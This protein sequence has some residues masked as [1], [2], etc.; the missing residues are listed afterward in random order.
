MSGSWPKIIRDP[1]HDLIAFEDVP[2]DRLLLDLLNAREVQRL[3]R[4]KQLG[5]TELVFPAANH[6][7]FAHSLGVLHI[8]RRFLDRF[9]QLTGH[10]LDEERRTLVLAAAL[11]HDVGHGP[12]SHA[13]EKVTG[14]NHERYTL[15]I[16]LDEQTEVHQKLRA[17]S[18]TLPQQ[19]AQFF[20]EETPPSGGGHRVPPYL[21]QIISSQLDADRCDYLLRDSH[22]TGTNYGNYDLSWLLAQ[23]R[24]Q[25]DGARFYLSRKA[26]SVAEAYLFARAHMYRTVYFHKTTRAAE[27]MLRLL[28]QRFKEL[29]AEA[30][31]SARLGVVPGAPGRAHAAFLGPMALPDYLRLDDHTIT[32]FLKGCTEASD[33]VLRDL[34]LGLLNRHLFKA[35][36]ATSVIQAGE[37]GK[38]NAF[39]ARVRDHLKQAG[40]DPR[41]AFADDTPGDTP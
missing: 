21:A 36:D 14:Q 12:F 16:I 35:T 23:L 25:P 8:A 5:L 30:T 18:S 26:L 41:F 3:R 22:A 10:G 4:I 20:D 28:F 39:D 9:Q 6:S 1:I 7:R 15:A 19:L 27:V 24:L 38:L 40:L 29:L 32:E 37:V 17:H 11:L 33:P 2:C 34:S 13:F 31:P